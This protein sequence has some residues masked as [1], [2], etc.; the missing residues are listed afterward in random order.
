MVVDRYIVTQT[1]E[2]ESAP[3]IAGMRQFALAEIGSRLTSEPNLVAAF[4]EEI[5]APVNPVRP[6]LTVLYGSLRWMGQT[7]AL[8]EFVSGETLEELVKRS[9]PASCEREIPLFCRILDA[10]DG[11]ARNG[12]APS[13]SQPGIDLI[14]FGFGRA[15]TPEKTKLHGAILVGPDGAWTEQIFGDIAASRREVCALLME[16]CAKLPGNLPRSSAFGTANLG[17]YAVGSL[18]GKV[19]PAK[20]IPPSAKAPVN[21]SLLARTMASPYVIAAATAVLTL[22][23]LQGVGGLLAKRSITA[24]AGRLLILPATQVEVPPEIEAEPPKITAVTPSSPK[25]PARQPI[26]SITLARGTRP[27]RQTSLE[28]PA[29]ARKERVSGTVEMQLTIAEDGS[30]QSPCV[31]SG[32]PLLRAGLAEEISKWVYQPMRVNGKPVPMTTELAIRFNLNP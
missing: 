4:W 25:R 20:P 28:Y 3:P 15:A 22:S 6:D 29:E 27:I 11:A 2:P 8:I 18:A 24:S 17:E 19:L 9:E 32:D 10:F 13:A 1:P 14:D 31:L 7:F 16:L 21:R 23:V 26:S 30:V 5:G 12:N